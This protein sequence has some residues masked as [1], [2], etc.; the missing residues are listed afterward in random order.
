MLR[1]E[2]VLRVEEML[3]VEVLLLV[4]L[5]LLKLLPI[6][7]RDFDVQILLTYTHTDCCCKVSY[8]QED[9]LHTVTGSPHH[10]GTDRS[11]T[12][13]CLRLHKWLGIPRILQIRTIL[14]KRRLD[15]F[16][17]SVLS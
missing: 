12:L 15:H 6:A 10:L 11:C 8:Q 1:V 3:R 7:T 17:H 13:S 9:L 5:L 4:V 2:E 14:L 16:K